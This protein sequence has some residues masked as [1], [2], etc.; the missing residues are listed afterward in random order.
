MAARRL[1]AVRAEFKGHRRRRP[2]PTTG[3]SF[4][5]PLAPL[6]RAG[7]DPVALTAELG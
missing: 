2:A 1:L 3:F 4:Y 7:A 5:L 6:V